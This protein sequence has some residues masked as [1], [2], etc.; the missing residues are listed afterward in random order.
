MANKRQ[1]CK[2]GPGPLWCQLCQW[3][4]A[5][6]FLGLQNFIYAMYIYMNLILIG[7]H[8]GMN[9]NLIEL[10]LDEKEKKDSRP[11]SRLLHGPWAVGSRVCVGVV[12][13]SKRIDWQ[14]YSHRAIPSIR[15][16]QALDRTLPHSHP[17]RR[18][19]TP[20]WPADCTLVSLP[21]QIAIHK[22]M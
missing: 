12:P 21:R 11:R 20:L 6:E 1:P 5:H 8:L 3:H 16:H 19:R 13:S 18:R 7:L 15:S 2:P 10:P 22:I 14:G 17:Q 4:R 9:L